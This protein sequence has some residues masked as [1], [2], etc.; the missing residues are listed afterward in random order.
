MSRNENLEEID[1]SKLPFFYRTILKIPLPSLNSLSDTFQGLFWAI[2]APVSLVAV[3][4]ASLL[5]L[6]CLPSPFNIIA[7]IAVPSV[8]ILVFL[9]VSIER[10]IRGW[11]ALIG[12]S[13]KERAVE[14]LLNEYL[15]ILK[16]QEQAREE[17]L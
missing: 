4:F 17:R 3:F 10:F 16:E 13:T 15:E 14:K 2:I 7:V 9:R 12:V 8:F 6:T 1:E 5:L 11:N